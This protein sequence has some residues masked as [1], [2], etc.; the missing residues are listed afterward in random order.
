MALEMLPHDQLFTSV[1]ALAILLFGINK[2]AAST[3]PT[4]TYADLFVAC[5]CF[6]S[7][8]STACSWTMVGTSLESPAP[9][10]YLQA[11]TLGV[12]YKTLAAVWAG[13]CD[14]TGPD[15]HNRLHSNEDD[16]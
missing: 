15:S 14:S 4:A 11:T 2:V 1:A 13:C 6:L 16:I 3:L 5:L 8:A 12:C 7:V 10:G 9:L